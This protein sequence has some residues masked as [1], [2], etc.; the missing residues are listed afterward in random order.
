[1]NGGHCI[2]TV[3]TRRQCSACRF[4]KCIAVGMKRGYIF[5]GEIWSVIMYLFS[6]KSKTLFLKP[7]SNTLLIVI[8]RVKRYIEYLFNRLIPI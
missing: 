4:K 1:M 7:N 8:L 3:A 2:T 5:R 6:K